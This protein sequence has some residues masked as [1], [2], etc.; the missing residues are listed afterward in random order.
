MHDGRQLGGGAPIIV[1][2]PNVNLIL[3]RI[4]GYNFQM[5]F[6]FFF[7]LQSRAITRGDKFNILRGLTILLQTVHEST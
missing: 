4:P 7:Y 1:L 6:F 3:N 5:V 2:I